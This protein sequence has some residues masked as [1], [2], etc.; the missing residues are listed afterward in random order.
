MLERFGGDEI[1]RRCHLIVAACGREY[2]LANT[3]EYFSIKSLLVNYHGLTGSASFSCSLSL[4][5][6]VAAVD[7]L[8]RLLALNFVLENKAQNELTVVLLPFPLSC[9]LSFLLL[10]V[11]RAAVPV[12][13]TVG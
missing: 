7:G 2:V 11:L 13:R 8:S 4:D 6:L 10:K 12:L 5:C 3:T 1:S 9:Q